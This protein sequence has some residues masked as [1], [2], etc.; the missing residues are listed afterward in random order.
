[1]TTATLIADNSQQ[2]PCPIASRGYSKKSPQQA[3]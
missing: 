3:C 1:M 2:C